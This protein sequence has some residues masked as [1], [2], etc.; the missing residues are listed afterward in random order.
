ME[1]DL[2]GAF[3]VALRVCKLRAVSEEEHSVDEDFT[4][5]TDEQLEAEL[6]LAASTP[7][8]RRIERYAALL[9]ERERREQERNV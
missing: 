9:A 7:N 4:G 6:T 2:F 5:L 8:S 1:T 3:P